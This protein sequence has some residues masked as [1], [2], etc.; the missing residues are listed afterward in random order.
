MSPS[1]SVY[2]TVISGPPD[3]SRTTSPALKVSAISI[4]QMLSEPMLNR[5]KYDPDTL[6]LIAK[7]E[8]YANVL[9]P[10]LRLG[11]IV[12]LNS[13]GPQAMVVDIDSSEGIAVG[14][15]DGEGTP[16]EASFPAACLHRLS[17]V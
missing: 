8:D 6:V 11:D 7:A 4:S 17:P 13:G 12:S 9:E 15:R 3:L 10:P 2:T 14:W 5:R 16:Q 1:G